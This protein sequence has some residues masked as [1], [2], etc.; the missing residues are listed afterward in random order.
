MGFIIFLILAGTFFGVRLMVEHVLG[1]SDEDVRSR[2]M[3]IA[4]TTAGLLTSIF[5]CEHGV[6]LFLLPDL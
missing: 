4:L 5:P 2:A 3:G 1:F 6:P